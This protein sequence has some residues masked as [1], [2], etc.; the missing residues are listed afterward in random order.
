MTPVA[1]I[2]DHPA[3]E[4]TVARAGKEDRHFRADRYRQY[5]LRRFYLFRHQFRSTLDALETYLALWI[6]FRISGSRIALAASA[7]IVPR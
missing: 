1:P 2:E 6:C 3:D 7:S 5:S 4:L